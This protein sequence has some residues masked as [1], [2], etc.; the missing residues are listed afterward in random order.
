MG[1]VT[2]QEA[3]A[4]LVDLIHRLIP[5]DEL[6]I[7]ENNRPVAKLIPQ[8]ASGRQPRKRGS[9]KGKLTIHT[10][11]EEHLEDFKEYMP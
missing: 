6:V 3:Q 10:E 7:T 5:G 2:I 4:K 1:T 8:P 9:A 11:D